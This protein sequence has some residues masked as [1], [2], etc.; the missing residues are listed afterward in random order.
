[1]SVQRTD[2]TNQLGPMSQ[3]RSNGVRRRGPEGEPSATVLLRL[4]TESHQGLDA[5][6]V[7]REL[8][9]KLALVLWQL[10]RDL[11]LWT[12]SP[13]S[14]RSA[15][16]AVR[17]S[18]RKRLLAGNDVPGKIVQAVRTIASL[19]GAPDV[20]EIHAVQVACGS[21]AEWASE[22][23]AARTAVAF[24]RAGALAATASGAA[25]AN[26][27]FMALQWQDLPRAEVWLRRAAKLSRHTDKITF[28]L[29]R[30]T[31]GTLYA[32]QGDLARARSAYIQAVRATKG[33]PDALEIRAQAAVGLFHNATARGAH[34]EAERAARVALRAFG[35]R[36]PEIARV[37]RHLARSWIERGQHRK[38]LRLL[39]RVRAFRVPRADRVETHTLIV[40]AAAA[41]AARQTLERAWQDAT[42]LLAK[43]PAGAEVVGMMVAL[44]T[45]GGG[46]VPHAHAAGLVRQAAAMAEALGRPDLIEADVALRFLREDDNGTTRRG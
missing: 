17:P 5:A 7:L 35:S 6:F 1:M 20:H 14:E 29:A 3:S 23:G 34:R 30:S 36:Y 16:F 27:G 22:Q 43:E 39:R 32:E 40:R 9:G 24:A 28:A 4:V 10:L 38:A 18:T 13:P 21:I 33:N 37:G 45:A 26:A 41:C 11:H 25:A 46:M 8:E 2:P 12:T 31:L 15:L 42:R 44:A 19:P